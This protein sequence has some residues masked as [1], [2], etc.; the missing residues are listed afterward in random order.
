MRVETVPVDIVS[1]QKQILGYC[2]Y[3]QALYVALFVIIYYNFCKLLDLGSLPI[4]L[5]VIIYAFVAIPFAAACWALGFFHIKKHD[6]YFDY[7][8]LI[9]IK[10]QMLYKRRVYRHGE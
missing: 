7:Y 8:A 10:H 5:Y 9:W 1:E 2:S 3:R 6:M 4:V